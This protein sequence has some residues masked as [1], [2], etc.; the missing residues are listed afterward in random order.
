KFLSFLEVGLI[1]ISCLSCRSSLI[2]PTT[3]NHQYFSRFRQHFFPALID[4]DGLLTHVSNVYY[5]VPQVWFIQFV[6][7]G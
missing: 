7:L 6:W 5:S 2:L 4:E 1:R 3:I